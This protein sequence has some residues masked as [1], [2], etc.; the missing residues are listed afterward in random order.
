M[1]AKTYVC[2]DFV[3]DVTDY[4][5]GALDTRTSRAVERHLEKCPHCELYIEQMR[6]T[7]SAVGQQTSSSSN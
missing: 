1:S 3:E 6:E 7:I 2:R 4:L 5:E